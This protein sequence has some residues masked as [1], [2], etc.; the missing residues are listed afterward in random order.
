MSEQSGE[1]L[2]TLLERA[3]VRDRD[4][5]REIAVDWAGG[6]RETGERLDCGE[7][8]ARGANGSASPRNKKA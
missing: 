2:R 6:D 5:D 7:Q 1:A 3:V 8:A 4:L